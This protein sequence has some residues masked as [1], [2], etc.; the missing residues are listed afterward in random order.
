[1]PLD[2]IISP[3][4]AAL[5]AALLDVPLGG[6]ISYAALSQISGRDVTGG[7]R[8]TLT[9][10]R[11]IAMRDNGAA[12]E[13]VRGRGLRR[14][15][16]EDVADLGRAARRKIR[17]ASRRGMTNMAAVSAATN[18]LPAAAQRAMTAEMASLGLIEHISRD[19]PT[20]AL[21]AEDAPLPPARAA[22]AFLAHIGAVTE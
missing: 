22:S 6:E 1:M 16:A 13:T 17:R 14:I 10:A 18:G 11:N 21:A 12:F 19:K 5:R 4:T 3:E 7:G 9:S 8:G 20:A 2:L 15:G